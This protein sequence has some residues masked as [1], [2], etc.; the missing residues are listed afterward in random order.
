MTPSMIYLTILVIVG[1]ILIAELPNMI[2]N[3]VVSDIILILYISY[4]IKAFF[5]Y[6]ASKKRSY[7]F[8]EH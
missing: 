6:P 5:I 3:F 1:T 8:Q 7:K 4:L 2:S